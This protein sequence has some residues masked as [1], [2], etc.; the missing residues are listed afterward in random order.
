MSEYFN[1]KSLISDVYDIFNSEAGIRVKNHL[2]IYLKQPVC[3]PNKSERHDLLREGENNIIRQLLNCIKLYEQ[4][5]QKTEIDED[6][7][8]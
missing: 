6:V 8:R 3:D 1:E 2:E 4:P 7:L 5:I